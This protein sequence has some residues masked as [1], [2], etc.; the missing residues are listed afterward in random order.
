[1]RELDRPGDHKE[2][3]KLSTDQWKEL[4][5]AAVAVTAAGCVLT[6]AGSLKEYI[7]I[8]RGG[9][10]VALFGFVLFVFAR[11]KI[12]RRTHHGPD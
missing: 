12:S 2:A 10:F 5:K 3:V 9:E 11:I 1:M 6:I 8:M 4:M 7:G